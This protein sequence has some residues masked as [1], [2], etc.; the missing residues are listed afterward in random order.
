MD[1]C[2]KCLHTRESHTDSGN[3]LM[4]CSACIKLCDKEEFNINHKP[5]SLDVLASMQIAREYS[6]Y[7]P[8]EIKK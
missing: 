1:I 5:T 3:N 8:E 2:G 7:I 4:Y 6:K